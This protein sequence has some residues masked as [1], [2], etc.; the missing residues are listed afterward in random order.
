MEPWQVNDSETRLCR[1]I[2]H[3]TYWVYSGTMGH[4]FPEARTPGVA[5][6]HWYIEMLGMTK[7][8]DIREAFLR[9]AQE[10]DDEDTTV[11]ET[12]QALAAASCGEDAGESD[13]V[14][15]LGTRNEQA[16]P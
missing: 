4:K 5:W 6:K 3:G 13:D 15:E 8:P 10:V 14:A 9:A 11:E 1:D 7:N 16:K 2:V 12:L